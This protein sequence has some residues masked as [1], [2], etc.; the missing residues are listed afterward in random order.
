MPYRRRIGQSKISGTLSGTI[1]AGT[2][3]LYT[4]A[5]YGFARTPNRVALTPEQTSPTNQ[6]PA[7][8]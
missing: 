4:I 8:Q 1:K 7:E 2:K 5:K 6:T 3:I